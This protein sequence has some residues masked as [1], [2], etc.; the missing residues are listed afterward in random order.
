MAGWEE[1]E[2]LTQT[3][4]MKAAREEEGG[5]RQ[6]H[7]RPLRPHATTAGRRKRRQR[8]GRGRP[9]PGAAHKCQNR[10]SLTT[11]RSERH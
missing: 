1:G 7:R 5:G 2:V 11:S 8:H 3:R 9:L 6:P 10:N 4:S